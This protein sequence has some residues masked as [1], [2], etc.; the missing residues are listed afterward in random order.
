MYV[1]LSDMDSN[2]RENLEVWSRVYIWNG[3]QH[4]CSHAQ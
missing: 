4:D 1:D 3:D 2:K